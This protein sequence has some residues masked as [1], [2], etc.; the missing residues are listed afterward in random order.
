VNADAF[1]RELDRQL[2]DVLVRL[3]CLSFVAFA[4]DAGDEREIRRWT[5]EMAPDLWDDGLAAPVK[6]AVERACR[7][8]IR[9]ARDAVADLELHGSRSATAR[10]IVRRLGEQLSARAKRD[11]RQ[12][13]FERLGPG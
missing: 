10:A 13:G 4:I 8:G 3:A 7:C 12:M 11:R 6:L 2:D 1:A 9:R 5:R